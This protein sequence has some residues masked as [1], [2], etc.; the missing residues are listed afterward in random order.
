M[1][2]DINYRK[3]NSVIFLKKNPFNE[4]YSQ[5][6]MIVIIGGND[7]FIKT[8]IESDDEDDD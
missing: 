5:K 6:N 8:Y 4:A 1:F 7:Q 2:V 3:F